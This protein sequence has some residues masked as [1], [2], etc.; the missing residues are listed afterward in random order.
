MSEH[1]CRSRDLDALI[2]AFIYSRRDD[3]LAKLA[4]DDPKREALL[5]QYQPQAWLA[6]AARRAGQLR[7]VT[8]PLKASHPDARGSSLF[9]SPE[10]LPRR[11]VAGSHNLPSLISDVV[12]N[13]AAL[14]VYKFLKLEHEGQ[15]LLAL[16]QA[17]DPDVLAALSDDLDMATSWRDAFCSIAESPSHFASHTYAKQIYWPVSPDHSVLPNPHDDRH[18]HLLAPLYSSS[19]SH[20]LYLQVQHDRFSEEAKAARQAARDKADHPHGHSVYPMLAEEKK[21]GTKPQNISQLNSERKGS[22]YLLSS[23]PPVWQRSDIRP[24]LKIESAFSVFGRRETVRHV[25]REFEGWLTKLNQSDSA[26][27]QSTMQVRNRRDAYLQELFEELIQFGGAFVNLLPPGWSADSACVL[28]P[29]ERFWLDPHRAERDEE[30]NL[31][32]QRQD[33]TEQLSERFARWLNARLGNDT[34][35][36]AEAEFRYWFRELSHDSVWQRQLDTSLRKQ[37]TRL[38]P[39]ARAKGGKHAR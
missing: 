14:D 24:L 19:L 30:F 39:V 3:K 29:E 8:H 27:N 36:L 4:D 5:A 9:V 38:L 15:S 21:G 18:Y 26:T 12:G 13:A 7:L 10:E 1:N 25:L 35:Q 22:N 34:L 31:A 23:L 20:W 33:W 37:G 32:L 16:M 6:D 11:E 17:N 2:K 28:P